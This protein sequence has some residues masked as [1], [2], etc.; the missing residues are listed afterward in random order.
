MHSLKQEKGEKIHTRNIK[1]ETYGH[2]D[3]SIIVQGE[4]V[5]ERLKPYY[6]I[7]G[8]RCQ[9]CIIHHMIIRMLIEGEAITI[10][11]V[12]TE[13]DTIPRQECMETITS[14]EKIIGMNISAGFTKQIKDI[15]GGVNGCTHLTSLVISMAPAA[16][17]GYFSYIAEKPLARGFS[18]DLIQ[19][20][21]VNSCQVWKEGGALARMLQET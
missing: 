13:I 7:K 10:K 14:L 12:E 11:K 3:K 18:S 5:D 8:E 2:D 20:Y 17:Q 9:P 16:V 6:N 19:Q 15:L 1:I 4:L 21:I